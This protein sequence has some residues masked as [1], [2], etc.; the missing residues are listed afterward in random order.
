MRNAGNREFQ[1][2]EPLLL[3][4]LSV[5]LFRWRDRMLY[6][7]AIGDFDR[8]L[9]YC[10]DAMLESL[11]ISDALLQMDTPERNVELERQ[12]ENL[13]RIKQLESM[14]YQQRRRTRRTQWS[15]RPEVRLPNRDFSYLAGAIVAPCS[16]APH[17]KRHAQ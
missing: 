9:K 7:L 8:A 4:A 16:T 2:R 3:Y 1:S 15:T 6:R 17:E 13:E 5:E 12:V 11:A 10:S 14:I